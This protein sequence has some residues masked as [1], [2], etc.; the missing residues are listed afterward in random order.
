M[1]NTGCPLMAPG[2]SVGS[3]GIGGG[4]NDLHIFDMI[5]V[6]DTRIPELCARAGQPSPYLVLQVI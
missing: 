1:S 5:G 6:T 3:S 2:T 4:S